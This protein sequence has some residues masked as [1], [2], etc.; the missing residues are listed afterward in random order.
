MTQTA[1]TPLRSDRINATRPEIQALRAAAVLLVVIFHLW[2]LRVTGGFA[3][4]DVFFVISGYLITAHLL[5]E[6]QRSGSVSLTI[7]W[8]R[9]VRRLLPASLFVLIASV[10]GVLIW[11]PVTYWQQFLRETAAAATYVL[12]WV[13]TRDAVDYLASENSSSPVQH[14][15]SLSVEEQFYLAWPLLIVLAIA[16]ARFRRATSPRGAIMAVLVVVT[17]V[18]LAF[19]IY[20]TAVSPAAAYFVTTTRAWEFG[21]GG[22]LA[23]WGN[24]PSRSVAASHGETARS[25]VSWLGW[26]AIAVTALTFTSDTPFPGYQALLPVAGTVAVIWAG[27]PRRAWA[28]TR[29]ARLR[30]VQALGDVSYSVY[31]WHWPLIVI[32]PFALDRELDTILK[33]SIFAVTLVLA[34]FT[35]MWIEDPFR[36]GWRGKGGRPRTVFVLAA[37]GMAVVLGACG[38]GY[39]LARALA[40]EGAK[41][42]DALIQVATPCLGAA[43][44]DPTSSKPCANSELDGVLLPRLSGMSDDTGGAFACYDQAPG[45]VLKSCHYG[46]KGGDS[47]KV[48]LVGDSHAAMLIPGLKEQ[49]GAMNWSLDTFVSRGCAWSAV[50]TADADH[51]CYDRRQALQE[52]FQFGDEYDVILVTSRRDPGISATAENPQAARM[53]AAWEPVIERG[54]QVIALADNPRITQTALD[55]VANSSSTDESASSC[56]ITS[57]EG[58]AP[59]DPLPAAVELAGAGAHLVDLSPYYCQ[60]ETCPLVIGH[61]IVY[62]DLHH[63]TATFSRTLTPYLIREMSRVLVRN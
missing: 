2:P 7:F 9:R 60:D 47:L 34:M 4:V 3:G 22:L 36:A 29:L 19:S 10:I 18:S 50:T 42:A 39:G 51:E 6:V 24:A 48:A 56:A 40:D 20:E 43:A 16:I 12:N 8:A 63:I 1:L 45:A 59:N 44:T 27:T 23:L 30:P 49:L 17:V 41:Q 26:G 33:I 52:R 61:V 37:A 32:V 21:A 62:R 14:F 13:L 5:K 28:P 46:P 58:F 54:T 57:K 53:A 15:W 31:L 35:K 25:I 11:V 38:G 55:C